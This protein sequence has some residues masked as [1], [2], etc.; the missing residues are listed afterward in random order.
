MKE[1]IQKALCNY[2]KKEAIILIIKEYFGELKIITAIL[3]DLMN[4]HP[5][6][7]TIEK[8]WQRDLWN[9]AKMY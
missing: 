6:S 5:P 9:I 4:Q 8:A 1:C 3:V 2:C 7:E